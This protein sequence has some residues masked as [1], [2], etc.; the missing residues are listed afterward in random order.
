[1]TTTQEKKKVPYEELSAIMNSHQKWLD[2]PEKGTR[3]HFV[4][5]DLTCTDFRGWN[6]SE[7]IFKNCMLRRAQFRGC[8][9][10]AAAFEDCDLTCS[11]FAYSR[12]ESCHF[13][14]CDCSEAIFSRAV[15]RYAAF[16]DSSLKASSLDYANARAASLR[17]VNAEDADLNHVELH[18]A[19]IKVCNLRRAYLHGSRL[20]GILVCDTDFR[21]ASL[22]C[23]DMRYAQ[24]REGTIIADAKLGYDTAAGG[25]DGLPI[26]QAACGFGS[27]NSTLTLL[28]E[29]KRKDWIWYTGCFE[30]T[31]EDLLQAVKETHGESGAGERY[32]KAIDYLVSIAESNAK[33]QKKA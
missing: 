21:A 6:L 27:R 30:G 28:A 2:D 17:R 18:A 25:L 1:M 13:T 24:F 9:V 7:A 23:T 12:A 5:C 11:S 26:Y 31:E 14:R 10:T 4:D 15:L 20:V 33:E 19:T 16:E 22:T 3:A 29:G 8:N 32:L